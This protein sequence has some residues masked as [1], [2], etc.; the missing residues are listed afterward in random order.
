M[1]YGEPAGLIAVPPLS[2]P[3]LEPAIDVWTLRKG[4]RVNVAGTIRTVG[5]VVDRGPGRLLVRWEEGTWTEAPGPYNSAFFLEAVGA[6][7]EEAA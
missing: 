3:T 4:D 5:A 1:G 2:A 7:L 6:Y